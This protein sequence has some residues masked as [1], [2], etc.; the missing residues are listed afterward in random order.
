MLLG[1][2]VPRSTLADF[3]HFATFKS[4][5][6][7]LRYLVDFYRIFEKILDQNISNREKRWPQTSTIKTH[8]L[9]TY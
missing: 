2:Q 7:Y 8:P 4:I 6:E 9:E 5:L 3:H 1:R